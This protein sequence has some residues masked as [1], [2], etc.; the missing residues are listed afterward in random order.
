MQEE[1]EKYNFPS[2][3][4]IEIQNP[5]HL[6]RK[7]EATDIPRFSTEYH[8]DFV[9]AYFAQFTNSRNPKAPPSFVEKEEFEKFKKEAAW[10]DLINA[11][12]ISILGLGHI[13]PGISSFISRW[14]Q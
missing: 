2:P 13:W 7:E 3:S 10:R 11:L 1:T 5:I 14:W 6:E 8:S 9:N 12:A 4:S